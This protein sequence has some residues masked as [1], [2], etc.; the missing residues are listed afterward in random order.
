V[1]A[2]ILPVT[3]LPTV[4]EEWRNPTHEEFAADGKTVWRFHNA[5]THVWKGRNLTALPRR[6]QALHGILDAVCAI[7]V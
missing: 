4:L 2:N 6:S 3:Q 5:V 1:D 7:A